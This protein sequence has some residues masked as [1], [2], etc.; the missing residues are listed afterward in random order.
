[1]SVSCEQQLPT[2]PRATLLLSEGLARGVCPDHLLRLTFSDQWFGPHAFTH[3][4]VGSCFRCVTPP[5]LAPQSS[6]STAERRLTL[7]PLHT[8]P[9]RPPPPLSPLAPPHPP[10]PLD[11]PSRPPPLHPFS[12]PPPHILLIS[13]PWV[14]LRTASHWR[15][16]KQY[17]TQ[18]TRLPHRGA[19]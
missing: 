1:M 7:T 3:E 8:S 15:T 9:P 12:P 11:P 13:L 18:V 17:S 19:C 6:G 2:H 10:P 14:D 4:V 16:R 5:A